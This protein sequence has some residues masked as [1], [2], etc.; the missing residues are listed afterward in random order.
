MNYLEVRTVDP[1]ALGPD[2]SYLDSDLF[3]FFFF[4][5]NVHIHPWG[6]IESCPAIDHIPSSG[7]TLRL[8]K[9]NRILFY[10]GLYCFGEAARQVQV[11]VTTPKEE[12]RWAKECVRV[13]SSECFN[14]R[15]S[16]LKLRKMVLKTLWKE[17]DPLSG[18]ER[19][20][21][22]KADWLDFAVPGC[23]QAIRTL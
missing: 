8:T 2:W 9:I 21:N 10:A 12:R 18:Q 23:T 22:I 11:S 13:N 6:Q 17:L 14:K 4:F 20:K 15:A 1:L 7:D 19:R 3:F 16:S 5:F